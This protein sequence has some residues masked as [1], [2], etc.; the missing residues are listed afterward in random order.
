MLSL[1]EAGDEA[2]KLARQLMQKPANLIENYRVIAPL[3]RPPQIRDAMCFELHIRQSLKS[4]CTLRALAA[5]IDP[6]QAL[7]DAAA[8]GQ[9]DIPEI[10]Y[11]QPVYYK[12]NR[13][14]VSGNGEE[15]PWPKYSQIM[16]YECELACVIGKQGKDI[17]SAEAK[18]HIFGYTIFNDF[19]ARDAQS[20]EIQGFLGPAKGKDFD[21]ANAMGQCIVTA[22]EFDPATKNA[23][24]VRVNGEERSNGCSSTMPWSFEQLIAH[25]SQAETLY[26]GE[27]LGS[28]TVGNGC[29]LEL[30]QFLNDGDHIEIEIPAIGVLSN[31][32]KR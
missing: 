2:M 25:V 21:K 28:G 31:T 15:I 13:F 4:V 20:A 16:D 11:Q 30:M 32:V 17:T 26:P 1:I 6:E 12:A 14:A 23:M 29:G 7:K 9:L 19:S 27:I 5:N 8:S 18:Q 10:W 3:P 24:I 22:D